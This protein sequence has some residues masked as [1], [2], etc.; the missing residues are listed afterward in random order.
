MRGDASRDA[1]L[2]RVGF[3]S[4]V[5]TAVFYVAWL[6]GMGLSYFLAKPW[7][8]YAPMA[9]S[10][11]IP[12]GWVPLMI[13][14]RRWAPEPRRIYGDIAVAFAVMYS[15]LL[16]MNY[17]VALTVTIPK[18]A[19]GVDVG[20]LAIQPQGFFLALEA[21]GYT[22][23]TLSALFAGLVFR[24]AGLQR[25][26]RWLLLITGAFALIIPLQMFW[27]TWPSPPVYLTLPREFTLVAAVILLAVMFG[28]REVPSKID[29]ARVPGSD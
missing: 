10:V 20:L 18:E 21:V 4:A 12:L 17:F 26:I 11:F 27:P 22:L 9:P 7:S 14:I 6:A 28:R 16:T 25:L 8:D 19:A 1:V 15:A 5:V 29:G 2:H 24:G 23:M 13:S 3:W